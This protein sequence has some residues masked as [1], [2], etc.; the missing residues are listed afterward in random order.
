MTTTAQQN[1]LSGD[2]LR[3][4]RAIAC[5]TQDASQETQCKVLVAKGMLQG[6]SQ[7]GYLL[8]PAGEHA[9]HVDLPGRVPGIDT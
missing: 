6:D 2:E 3:C 5:G 7:T 1:I 4:L 9:I 8:T